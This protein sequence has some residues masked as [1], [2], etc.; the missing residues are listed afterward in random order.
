MIRRAL[1]ADLRLRADT[2]RSGQ[3]AVQIESFSADLS[4]GVDLR[5]SWEWRETASGAPSARRRADIEI[6]PGAQGCPMS[7]VP[8]R[9]SEALARLAERMLE[10]AAA[11]RR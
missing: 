7:D 4:C 1:A 5:A 2:T 10:E 9:M 3:V 11:V 6:P 8:A